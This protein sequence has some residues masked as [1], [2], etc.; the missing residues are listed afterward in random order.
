MV[1]RN[2]GRIFD[3]TNPENERIQESSVVK[4]DS[5]CIAYWAATASVDVYG[6]YIL[7]KNEKIGNNIYIESI[8]YTGNY[9]QKVPALYRV[10]LNYKEG[11]LDVEENPDCRMGRPDLR[12]SGAG[13]GHVDLLPD[14]GRL[15]DRLF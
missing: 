4:T 11:R 13:R 8:D 14:R 10:L 6:N 2:Y 15:L 1:L 7:Y 9:V 5:G 12:R 3:P